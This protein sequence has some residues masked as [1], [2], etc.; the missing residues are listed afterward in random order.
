MD[1]F[2]HL[3]EAVISVNRTPVA[4]HKAEE[5]RTRLACEL[6]PRL[7]AGRLTM[8]TRQLL[9]QTCEQ[10]SRGDYRAAVATCGHMVRSGG[11]FV[12]VSAFLPA[13]KSLFL[14]AQSTGDYRAAVATCGHMVR[15]GG[16]FVEL[17]VTLRSGRKYSEPKAEK[18]FVESGPT[19]Q[20]RPLTYKRV[21]NATLTADFSEKK[22]V[23]K[24]FKR[25]VDEEESSQLESKPSRC[26]IFSVK[27][28]DSTHVS[29]ETN[30]SQ[31]EVPSTK[32]EQTDLSFVSKEC[33]QSETELSQSEDLPIKRKEGSLL[34][35]LEECTSP[36]NVIAKSAEK[37]DSGLIIGECFI[38]V[39]R[40]V[41]GDECEYHFLTHGHVR[42]DVTLLDANH[43]PGS[44][45][46]LFEGVA[47]PG[48]SVL[49][50]GHF[51]ADSQMLAL[52]DT[53]ATYKK[54][55]QTYI[56]TIYLD[57]T[58]LNQARKSLPERKESEKMLVD[59]VRK[60]SEHS[61]I[62][63]ASFL[64]ME[65]TLAGASEQLSEII[66]VSPRMLPL[67]RKCGV[68]RGEFIAI[69]DRT[70][71]RIRV[72]SNNSI[73]SRCFEALYAFRKV[74]KPAM[75]IDLSPDGEHKRVIDKNILWIPYSDH[76][77][78][79]EIQEFLSRL[80]YG[81]VVNI[82]KSNNRQLQTLRKAFITLSHPKKGR[83]A[84]YPPKWKCKLKRKKPWVSKNVLG[85]VKRGSEEVGKAFIMRE[86]SHSYI[87]NNFYREH[88]DVEHTTWKE[89][90][91]S[92]LAG[93]GPS[94]SSQAVPG[95][96]V[97]SIYSKAPTTS[98]SIGISPMLVSNQR[99]QVAQTESKPP[100]AN[101][102]ATDFVEYKPDCPMCAKLWAKNPSSSSSRGNH[103]VCTKN[104]NRAPE[105]SSTCSSKMVVT[106][107]EKKPIVP[108]VITLD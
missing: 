91:P 43:C 60:L 2:Y 57:G 93:Y 82:H 97:H 44:V 53:D 36:P 59:E 105:V 51:R 98:G 63:I 70:S 48:G 104:L 101:S 27:D 69:S 33:L 16:D 80:R 52:F 21:R 61:I 18:T 14:L 99:Q 26:E 49:V 13:L 40:F 56:S 67:I 77:S 5:A 42:V 46:F 88:D 37:K 55:S 1:R 28:E 64:G 35:A 79:M 71:S 108:A 84:T 10:A 75:I 23:V 87:R 68:E 15:S 78:R 103:Q 50:T 22:E 47:V 19:T 66:S 6:A 31:P 62:I 45:M 39:D 94:T 81:K 3:I 85:G 76:S 9:W 102:L 7:A 96:S 65:E 17:M 107:G 41:V 24:K 4:L 106:K 90:D 89:M 20:T 54:L 12:E 38:A 8:G 34:R 92:A 74:P 25:E 83:K 29:K 11:D 72:L 95:T 30:P 32:R 58:C 100:M 86:S 73:W